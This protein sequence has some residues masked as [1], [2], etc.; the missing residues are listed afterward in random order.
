MSSRPEKT[1][2]IWQE[3]IKRW[4][5]SRLPAKEFIKL[6]GVSDCSLYQWRKRFRKEE[7]SKCA[8]QPRFVELQT[9]EASVAKTA[10]VPME[11]HKVATKN[12]TRFGIRI[13]NS[14]YIEVPQTFEA[15]SRTKESRPTHHHERSIGTSNTG[16]H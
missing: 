1:R 15:N 2:E 9:I 11:N 3:R 13:R 5:E 14:I 6:E 10:E 7:E 8:A 16:T 4:E 12:D